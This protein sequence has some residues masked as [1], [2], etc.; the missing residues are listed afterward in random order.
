MKVRL[1]ILIAFLKLNLFK[2]TNTFTFFQRTFP[3]RN[4]E[5][6]QNLNEAVSLQNQVKVVRLQDKLG[7]QNIHEDLR[8]V[9][10][11]ITKSLENTSDK[12][13]KTITEHSIN[14]N[15]A[16]ENLN[17][18]NLELMNDKGLMAPYLTSSLVEVFKFDNKSQFRLRKDPNSTKIIDFLI[19][20]NIPVTI[21]S[22]MII[23]RDSEKT[24]KLEGDLLK[25]TTNYKFNVDHSNQ[26]DRKI[27][28]EFAKE[29]NYDTKSTGRPS[30]RH[31]SMIRLLDKPAIIA[32]GVSKTII[33]SSDPNELCERLKLL[34]Q[35]KHG[36]K[37]SNLIDGE[38]VAIIDKLLEYKCLSKKQHKQIL[39][40]CN[41]L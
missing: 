3:I 11:P 9:F 7:K 22:N 26:Q 17:E 1:H 24:F 15:K 21:F 23:F 41:L 14:N 38:I 34:L 37:N 2:K 18:K 12:I 4:V 13:T 5:D 27:I 8:E 39:I 20:G 29:M 6:L 30:V 31:E 36:G 28:Y 25:V 35:E 19:H 33:L 40:K 16:I 10:E 32:S